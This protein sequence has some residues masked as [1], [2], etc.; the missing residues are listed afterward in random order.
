MEIKNNSATK[1]VLIR[2][3]IPL[4]GSINIYSTTRKSKVSLNTYCI[5]IYK[6]VDI[7]YNMFEAVDTHD[8]VHIISY[9]AT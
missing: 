4:L 8:F 1:T 7:I 3:D 6:H 9:I 5:N 2:C